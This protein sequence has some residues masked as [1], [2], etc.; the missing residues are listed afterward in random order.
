MS[1]NAFKYQKT[2]R[3]STFGNPAVAKHILIA[4]HG[5]GQL[6]PFF[7]RKFNQLD[8]NQYFVV[9][10]EGPHRF[11]RNGTSGRVGASWMTKEER[12]T[13]IQDYIL[14]LDQLMDHVITENSFEKKTLLGFSQGGATASRW[15]AYGRYQ[16]DQFLL[17]AAVFPPDMDAHF[18][19]RFESS[20]NFWIIGDQ[21]E[22]IS[23]AKAKNYFEELKKQLKRI[24]F[25]N[26]EGTHDI[27]A[28]TLNTFLR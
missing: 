20:E 23:M 18:I 17:W 4:L 12:E 27:D 9:C 10:P 19:P 14:F 11:Y 15:L 13:D 26:F 16:F 28:A 2:G 7:I 22:F 25:V 6:A 3:Y 24:E 21:D 5:Y 8:P 1:T